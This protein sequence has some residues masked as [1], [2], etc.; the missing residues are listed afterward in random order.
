M[1]GL[2]LVWPPL[3][4]QRSLLLI[5]GGTQQGHH[6][7]IRTAINLNLFKKLDESNGEAKSSLELAKMTCADPVLMGM[8]FLEI[9]TLC[10]VQ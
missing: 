3:L 1:S 9:A 10:A 5:F 4:S 6:A 2:R 7:A 8:F